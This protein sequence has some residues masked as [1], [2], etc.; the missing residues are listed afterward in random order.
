MKI[1][2][3][4]P[5]L[6][7]HYGG[8]EKHFLTT[9]W[10]L[11][12]RHEVTIHIPTAELANVAQAV[13]RYESLFHLDLSNVQWRSSAI[14]ERTAKPWQT[15][16]I[17]REYDAFWYQTDGSV[18]WNGSHR[19]VLHV[20]IP[21][22]NTHHSRWARWKLSSWQV[23]NT[24]SRFT[25]QV[26]ER[27]WQRPVDVVHYP[28]VDLSQLP[29]KPP[30]KKK[31]IL[32]VGRFYDP[33]HT[34]VHAKRQDVLVEAFIAGCQQH[35]WDKHGWSLTLVGSVEPGTDHQ[36]FVERLQQQADQ[37][38]ITFQHDIPYDDLQTLYLESTLFWHAAGFGIDAAAQ[39]QRVEHFG[40]APL[41]AMAAGAIPIVTDAGGLQEIVEPNTTGYR[42]Q[43]LLELVSQ[44][45]RVM[46]MS[47]SQ[48]QTM[49]EAGRDHANEFSL[50]RFCHTI[51]Q[52]LDESHQKGRHA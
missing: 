44:T 37:Y 28:Y 29:A 47:E 48:R 49:R 7:R 17:T 4:S 20:Q 16:Q 19:G 50:E 3:Y 36:R 38:P 32:A 40:M 22:T 35:Q 31:T 27:S 18:F 30:R 12:Q 8:G 51:D 43:T 26:I 42:F 24:N 1:G 13:A 34:D 25:A 10:Y 21:F 39:P 15:W 6:P 5:Y 46:D 52:M 2:L 45:Q 33:E 9:A 41:E 11:S 14:A 23:L